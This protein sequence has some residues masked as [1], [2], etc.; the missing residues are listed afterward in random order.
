MSALPCPSPPS[1]ARAQVPLF[2][3][4]EAPFVARLA[5]RLRLVLYMS[6]EVVYRADSVGQDM[7]VVWKVGKAGRG[8]AHPSTNATLCLQARAASPV[9]C[10][11]PRADLAAAPTAPPSL[12]PQ[13]AVAL[14]DALGQ[15]QDLVVDGGHFGEAGL[16]ADHGLPRHLA[17]RALKP[18]DVVL[19]NKWDL[20]VGGEQEAALQ[21]GG[22]TAG[23]PLPGL[24]RASLGR[25]R[26]LV[27][28]KTRGA[29]VAVSS[30]PRAGRQHVWRSRPVPQA[31][32]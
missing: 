20:Q 22:R 23:R 8:C 3:H 5:Q 18:S 15:V 2:A 9:V 24:P 10:V 26:G 21:G 32:L 11:S 14:L 16:M 12:A 13:G 17:A 30:G 6:G 28:C 25:S 7:F 29:C 31:P 27:Q 19:L 1:T 4:T